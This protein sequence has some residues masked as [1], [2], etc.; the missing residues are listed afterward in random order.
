MSKSKTP[1]KQAT[2]L[3][4]RFFI[5]LFASFRWLIY[6]AFTTP[7]QMGEDYGD[8]FV[9]EYQVGTFVLIIITSFFMLNKKYELGKFALF[10]MWVLASLILSIQLMQSDIGEIEKL[11]FPV[12][13]AGFVYLLYSNHSDRK[14][15]L[16]DKENAKV[17]AK[18]K[19]EAK[20]LK[21]IKGQIKALETENSALEK[22]LMKLEA[23]KVTL[24]KNKN[25]KENIVNT[26]QADIEEEKQK[27]DRLK[28]KY[29]FLS[30]A[31]IVDNR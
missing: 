16:A 23:T 10:S 11:G 28:A 21:D 5:I 27:F 25:K 4:K 17:K 29:P 9:V 22:T 19:K 30:Q 8:W 2:G 12:I 20:T 26:L 31:K 7:A 13:F 3:L 1:K 24:L 6:S 15:E 14:Q 18:D